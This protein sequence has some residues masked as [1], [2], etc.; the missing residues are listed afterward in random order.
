QTA[1]LEFGASKDHAR[2][3]PAADIYSLAKTT[4]TIICGVSP[5]Q[6]AHRAISELPVP[7][8]HEPWAGSLVRVLKRAT[9]EEPGA[10]YQTVKDFWDD[11][12]DVSMPVTRPLTTSATPRERVSSELRT[13]DVLTLAAPPRPR[14]QTS[15]EL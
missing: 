14:F 5:R 2:L 9:Q 6:F 4:Y 8:S 13:E 10:R 15:R 7:I 11:L 12:N 1:A 3:T